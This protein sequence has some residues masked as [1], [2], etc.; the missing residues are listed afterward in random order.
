MDHREFI[1]DT[2]AARV[3]ALQSELGEI[4]RRRGWPTISMAL[5]SYDGSLG[6][7]G[8][9]YVHKDDH[10]TVE[11]AGP[12]GLAL[13]SAAECLSAGG[14]ALEAINACKGVTSFIGEGLEG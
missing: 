3:Q 10:D 14:R 5:C 7:L 9:T 1:T 8:G 11:A 4:A 12:L 2:D 6:A 13:I